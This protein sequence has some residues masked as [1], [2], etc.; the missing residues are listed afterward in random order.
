MQT[1][2]TTSTVQSLG[3]ARV[4]KTGFFGTHHQSTAFLD[5]GEQAFEVRFPQKN[6]VMPGDQIEL[7][8]DPSDLVLLK[9]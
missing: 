1:R 7:Y 5:R 2:K 9:S 4:L 8:V 6:A 3:V